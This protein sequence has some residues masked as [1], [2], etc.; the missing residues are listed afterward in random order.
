MLSFGRCYSAY[1]KCPSDVIGILATCKIKCSCEAV[2]CMFK[3]TSDEAL[4]G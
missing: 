3:Y 2:V 4:R 1:V